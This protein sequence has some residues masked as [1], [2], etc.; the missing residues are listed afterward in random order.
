MRTSALTSG[1]S[2]GGLQ[3]KSHIQ[4]RSAFTLVE[5]LV[6]IAIIAILAALLF[7]AFSKVRAKAEG[8]YCISNTKQ[9]ALAW[10]L[11]ADDHN[12]RLAYNL[13]GN[14]LTRAVA[15]RTN[16]NWVNNIM[17]WQIDPDNTN[18]ATI[19]EAS[20]GPYTKAIDLYRCPSDRVL[21]DEQRRAG[22]TARLRSYS[23]NAMVG[24]AGEISASGT[25]QNNPKYIQFF[26][27]TDIPRPSNIFVFLDEHPD[28]INDGY[29]VNKAYV[30][31]WLD[32]P[33][34]YH[35]GA[36]SL[37]FAD[38]H[39]DLHRWLLATTKPPPLPDAAKLPIDISRG[40]ADMEWL[41][42]RMS[43]EPTDSNSN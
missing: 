22:W 35:N 23:M 3:F 34:S 39:S 13:G 31:K 8:I 27:V 24:D 29:F 20:L 40:D 41:I 1:K 28:S 25:N 9:L 19:T 37:S 21:S 17:S 33:A 42:D 4:P 15:P 7:P 18:V 11:Y 14:A 43:I 6:V 30:P 36:T 10:T 5:L 2:D 38:G 16:V 26:R 32:L 12:G